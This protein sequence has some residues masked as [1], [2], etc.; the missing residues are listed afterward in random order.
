M[1]F[2]DLADQVV[3]R[4]YKVILE[5]RDYKVILEHRDYKV[6]PEHKVIPERKV[7][8]DLVDL[9]VQDLLIHGAA[10]P[11]LGILPI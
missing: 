7:I 5:N 2:K 8:L 10:V 1:E 6:I 9:V 4:D 3:H 11:V